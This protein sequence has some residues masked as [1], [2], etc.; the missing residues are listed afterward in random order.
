MGDSPPVLFVFRDEWD[1]DNLWVFKKALKD[2][3]VNRP[4]KLVLY[5]LAR[6]RGDVFALPT[7]PEEWRLKE[8]FPKAPFV[9]GAIP[10]VWIGIPYRFRRV[11]EIPETLLEEFVSWVE[12]YLAQLKLLATK[13]VAE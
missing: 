2:L 13:K 3:P 6:R 9:W 4:V 7:A 1:E 5:G 12:E 8:E 11:E 10:E